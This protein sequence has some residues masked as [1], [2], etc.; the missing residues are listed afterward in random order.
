MKESF[1]AI[2]D[3]AAIA[4]TYLTSLLHDR[5]SAPPLWAAAKLG[6]AEMV[7]TIDLAPSYW[8]VP[9]LWQDHALGHIDVYRDGQ[10]LG[11][12]ILCRNPD[13][14]S[15]CPRVVTRITSEEAY[16]EA[17]PILKAYV[18][19]EF[20]PPVFAHDGPRNRLAWMIQVHQGGALIS[21]VFV[22]PGYAYERRADVTPPE[23][24]RGS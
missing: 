2:P 18:A 9:V 23:G 11:H 8:I 21:R 6:P 14:L 5:R 1:S 10:V 12:S 3:I 22:T 17:G 16:A 19:A 13:D 15:T 4:K 7:Y 24:L 20:S